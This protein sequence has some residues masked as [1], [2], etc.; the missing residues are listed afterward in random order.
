MDDYRFGSS[1]KM[2]NIKYKV[3]MGYFKHVGMIEMILES[4]IDCMLLCLNYVMCVGYIGNCC[5]EELL[6][7]W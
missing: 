5:L 2:N 1:S 3:Q 7:D 4:R 6:C